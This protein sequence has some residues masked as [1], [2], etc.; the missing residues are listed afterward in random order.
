MVISYYIY[1]INRY[2]SDYYCDIM[3]Y[4]MAIMAIVISIAYNIYIAHIIYISYCAY[5]P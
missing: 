1:S 2:C 4:Y 5:K 3:I